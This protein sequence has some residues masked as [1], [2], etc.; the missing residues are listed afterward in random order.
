MQN[1]SLGEGSG[2]VLPAPGS[3]GPWGIDP[4]ELNESR[5]SIEPSRRRR[6]ARKGG[7]P[8]CEAPEN[9]SAGVEPPVSAR[10]VRR[11]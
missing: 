6:E 3:S 1:K 8:A 9:G 10:R 11:I 7:A 5:R 2:A 4:Y